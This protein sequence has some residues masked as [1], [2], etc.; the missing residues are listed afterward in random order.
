MSPLE[1]L[2]K[3]IGGLLQKPVILKWSEGGEVL[4]EEER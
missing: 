1:E 4:S 3:K 2:G